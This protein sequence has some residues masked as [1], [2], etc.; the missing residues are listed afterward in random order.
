[1]VKARVKVGA[2][3]A[4]DSAEHAIPDSLVRKARDSLTNGLRS[5]GQRSIF[6]RIARFDHNLNGSVSADELKDASA[7]VEKLCDTLQSYWINN[8]VVSALM[9]TMTLPACASGIE[10]STS[11]IGADT[12]ELLTSAYGILMMVASILCIASILVAATMYNE[13]TVY[14]IDT[15]DKLWYLACTKARLSEYVMVIAM[16]FMMSG[17]VVGAFLSFGA[18]VGVHMLI[19]I[20]TTAALFAIWLIMDKRKIHKYLGKKFKEISSETSDDA[21]ASRSIAAASRSIAELVDAACEGANGIPESQRAFA[22]KM[23]SGMGFETEKDFARE[24]RF[25]DWARHMA[26]FPAR[27]ECCLKMHFEGAGVA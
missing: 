7:D 10:N 1:M 23:I 3:E 18:T 22:A 25:V 12:A 13:L 15:N 26:G 14:M 8:G 20:G 2:A 16:I 11:S 24:F 21:A 6:F 4:V 17:V 19:C 5:Y 9:L 27:V